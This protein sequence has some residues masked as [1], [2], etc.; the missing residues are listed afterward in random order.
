MCTMINRGLVALLLMLCFTHISSQTCSYTIS[1]ALKDKGTNMPLPYATVYIQ[2]TQSGAVADSVGNFILSNVCAGAYHLK[3]SHIGCET[4]NYFLQLSAD[5]TIQIFLGHHTE[6]LSETVVQGK[7]EDNTAKVSNTIGRSEI[8]AQSSKSLA[9]VLENIAGVSVLKNGSG[10]SK[11]VVHGL[12]GNR[13]AIL[14]NGIAQAGQQWGNDHAPE[15]DPF[16]ADHISVVKG[17]S[18][19][20]Y[21]GNSL[22]SVV[23]VDMDNVNQ[24]PHLHG[25]TNYL[26]QSNGLGH[27]LN[28][29][30]EKGGKW[31]QWRITGTLKARGD[32]KSPG[33]YLSNTGN[34]EGNISVQLERRINT[35]INS[36]IYYS[37]FN[38]EI[39]IL[40]GS[41]I[42]NLTDLE[43]AITRK[44]P[45]FTQNHFTYQIEA[46]RQIVQHHLLKAQV[47]CLLRGNQS[48]QFTYGGQLN[49]RKEFDVRRSGR[50]NIPALSLLQQSHFAEGVYKTI[51]GTNLL[52]KSGIQINYT[53]NTNNSETG[54]LPLI[55]DYR[56]FNAAAFAIL[57]KDAGRVFY[58]FGGRYSF[59][60]LDAVTITTTL[61]RKIERYNTPFHNY[62]I[63]GAVK[64]SAAANYKITLDAGYMLRSP[65]VNEL[66][67]AGLH[68]GVSGIEEGNKNLK[69]EQS[70]KLLLSNDFSIGKRL[71]VQA[72]TYFQYI[73]NYIYLQPQQE[74]RLTIRGA[75]PLFVYRQT[76]ATLWGTD[77][78]LTFEPAERINLIL[79]YA[80]VR[81]HDVSDN[82][83]LV[84]IPSD[85]L[86]ASAG[87][88]FRNF[89]R[90]QNNTL[91]ANGRYVWKQTRLLPEQDFLPPP[92]G[93]F[94]L[95]ATAAT[96]LHLK[97]SELN[98]TFTAD[99]LFNTVYRDYLNRQRYFANEPGIN[100]ELKAGY[101]F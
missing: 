18:V 62:A 89:K 99:N 74:F 38:T 47:N 60:Q 35:K 70:G 2:E 43:E 40:R 33:Y 12:Y 72:L 34:R 85:N 16:A 17:A 39:A 76:D 31:L 97:D 73:G 5:T 14:N 80:M 101:V 68:Q 81:G 6:L 9:G 22:G 78:L 42:G 58:E 87:Y 25:E 41:H 69:Q 82:L 3:F 90:F 61:P 83:P 26:F 67:S 15:I 4:E 50:E 75:F 49:N 10:I 93:Y 7:K 66:Y 96:A 51:F 13:I 59:Q 64:Y 27:T 56:A 91:S 19:L 71:F 21:A 11:P 63:S 84:N 77:L 86:F 46:P 100:I 79:K 8:V 37:L 28:A 52:L 32:Q 57:Q 1:G 55:P 30:L 48:L 36:K 88:V 24:D 23:L 53:D 29:R 20:A 92:N 95:G 98:F 45:F 54:I 44:V 65:E 94:L